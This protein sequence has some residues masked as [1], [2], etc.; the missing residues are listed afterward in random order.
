MEALNLL[1]I[2]ENGMTSQQFI[3]ASY[4]RFFKIIKRL[5]EQT[6]FF[7]EE[8]E[9]RKQNVKNSQ[10]YTPPPSSSSSSKKN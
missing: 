9:D 4:K 6:Q 10:H 5:D 2:I 8:N 3:G 1:Q 7:P